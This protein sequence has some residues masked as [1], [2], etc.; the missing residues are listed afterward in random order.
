MA[1]CLGYIHSTINKVGLSPNERMVFLIDLY[2]N[3]PSVF[4]K[5]SHP[6]DMSSYGV[7]LTNIFDEIYDKLRKANPSRVFT[8]DDIPVLG[9]LGRDRIIVIER[10]GH[11]HF[12]FK[13][14]EEIS[15][16]DYIGL[17]GS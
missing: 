15:S 10:I 14:G 4:C 13:N 8:C 11:D 17:G 1:Y 2:E 3:R 12:I 16:N 5:F 6:Y 7:S 9:S